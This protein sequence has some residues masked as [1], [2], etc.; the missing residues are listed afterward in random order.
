MKAIFAVNSVNGFGTGDDMPWPRSSIDLKRFKDLTSG[1]T[2]IMG[3]AT[4]NSNMPKPLPGRRNIVLSKSLV[5]NRCEV[6]NNITDLLMNTDK[7]E[8]CWVIGGA[9]VLWALRPNVMEVHLTIFDDTS[10]ATVTLDPQKYLDG[11]RLMFKE[12]YDNHQYQIWKREN[13]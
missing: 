7:S 1:A 9:R 3:S 5:D 8:E 12:K 2:V 13:T 10:R 6:Y 4:W 11:F